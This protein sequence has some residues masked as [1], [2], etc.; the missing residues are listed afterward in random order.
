MT[1]QELLDAFLAELRALTL[2]H[3]VEISGC[4]CC[5]SPA[6][7]KIKVEDSTGGARYKVQGPPDE[8]CLGSNLKWVQE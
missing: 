2:K 4:G 5:G 6:L 3:G 7:T 8:W 1:N